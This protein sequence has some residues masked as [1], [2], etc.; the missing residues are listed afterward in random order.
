[1]NQN[2]EP[3]LQP[4]NLR[5]DQKALERLKNEG[6]DNVEYAFFIEYEKDEKNETIDADIIWIKFNQ[7][8]E[9]EFSDVEAVEGK[10]YLPRKSNKEIVIFTPGFPGGNAGRFEQR[11]A[12]DFVDSGYTFFTVRHN[13]TSL[14]NEEKS[15]QIINAPKRLELAKQFGE[16]YLGGE[17]IYQPVEIIKETISPLMALHK[18]FQ[19]INLMGQSMGV[20][21]SYQAAGRVAHLPNIVNKLGNIVG[22]AGFIGSE[23]GGLDDAWDGLKMPMKDLIEYQ[24]KHIKEVGTNTTFSLEEIKKVVELNKIVK[25]PGQVNN[26]LIFT[27]ND[28]LIAG[29]LGKEKD[30]TLNYGPVSKRKLIIRDETNLE[31]KKPH[32]M[33]WIDGEVLLRALKIETS[34]LGPHYVTVSKKTG[35]NSKEQK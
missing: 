20:A 33:L 29:P 19:K 7:P 5:N 16:K 27:P 1:M 31:A 8:K 34:D 10:L 3:G 26:I 9:Q 12:K 28:P 17:K 11:Y 32:S 24:Q 23:A 22:I 13:G 35:V 30:Y 21:A 14:V 4:E 25:V 15:P 6:I 2:F 18:K